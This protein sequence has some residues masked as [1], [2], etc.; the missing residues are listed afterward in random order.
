M[1]PSGVVVRDR[2]EKVQNFTSTKE[3]RRIEV[4]KRMFWLF[5]GMSM[6]CKDIVL[7]VSDITVKRR[8]GFLMRSVDDQDA[9]S[10]AEVGIE[11]KLCVLRSQFHEACPPSSRTLYH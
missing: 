3:P 9:S 2:R 10:L 8:I 11:L 5:V 7:L 6:G 4:L 1:S